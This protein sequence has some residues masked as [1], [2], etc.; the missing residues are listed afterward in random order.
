MIGRKSKNKNLNEFGIPY[1]FTTKDGTRL[2]YSDMVR[3]YEKGFEDLQVEKGL[4]VCKYSIGPR[5]P[6]Q[7]LFS[8]GF[9][10]D[11]NFVLAVSCLGCGKTLKKKCFGDPSFGDMCFKVHHAGDWLV[12]RSDWTQEGGHGGPRGFYCSECSHLNKNPRTPWHEEMWKEGKIV[13]EGWKWDEDRLARER[14]L[15]EL[16]IPTKNPKIKK[17]Q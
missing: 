4:G 14:A 1:E 11:H 16:H 9:E 8:F 17:K 15:E 7:A 2:T 13:S 3:R 10:P 6:A 12:S 5:D